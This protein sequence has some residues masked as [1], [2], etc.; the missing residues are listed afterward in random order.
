MKYVGIQSSIWKNKFKTILLS[1]LF[2][3]FFLLLFLLAFAIDGGMDFQNPYF[4]NYVYKSSG[5][6]LAISLPIIA[7][8]F[9]IAFSLHR[10]LIFKFS[11]A[12]PVTRK[13]YP[14]IY[15]IVENLC[16]SR[17]LPTPNIG[18]LEDNSLNAFA[19]G[20]KP[21]KS[22]IVFSK[23][24]MDTLDKDEIESVAAHELTHIINKDTLLM[25]CVIVF[26]GILGTLW[27]IILRSAGRVGKSDNEWWNKAALAMLVIGLWLI[28]LGYLLFPVIRLAISRK[29]EYLADAGSV[30]L[31]K[32]N[33]ALISA[34]Q[35]ISQDSRIE[36]IKK[37]TVAAMCI[38]TP[39]EK[40]KKTHKVKWFHSLLATHP[41]IED[42]IAALK[43]Y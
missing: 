19:T 40:D 26:I 25:V 17:G 28:V 33:K 20:R 37:Q 36:S 8:W 22:R 32:N 42:R 31:T 34:L 5:M 30:E 3:V 43:N 23:W 27:E 29:R 14:E 35:K 41:S 15:N 7:I 21:G 11:G 18:I 38:E 2:P 13:D 12:K 16:I 9:V 24:L 10:K 39:F 4:W 1:V 6:A